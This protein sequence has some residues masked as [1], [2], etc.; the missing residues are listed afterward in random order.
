M[1]LPIVVPVPLTVWRWFVQQSPLL[2][3][4]YKRSGHAKSTAAH[5]ETQGLVAQSRSLKGFRIMLFALAPC[6]SFALLS[7]VA[8]LGWLFW[9]V[10]TTC[11]HPLSKYPGPLLA[12]IS[13]WWLIADTASGSTDR[14]QSQLHAKYGDPTPLFGAADL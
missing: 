9:V 11:F 3:Y 7:S 4:K 12:S 13:R 5:A 6:S 14:T 8:I 10:Y 1:D 2:Y